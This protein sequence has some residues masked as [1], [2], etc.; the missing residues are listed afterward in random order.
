MEPLTHCFYEWFSTQ[1]SM[2]EATE[3][4]QGPGLFWFKP[5]FRSY[6]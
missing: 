2:G 3:D 1:Y 5:I 4:V 6:V